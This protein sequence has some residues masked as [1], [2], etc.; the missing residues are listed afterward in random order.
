M[1]DSLK[2]VWFDSLDNLLMKDELVQYGLVATLMLD[3]G[4]LHG[5]D[6]FSEFT[7]ESHNLIHGFVVNLSVKVLA[8]HSN[9]YKC[10]ICSH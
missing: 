8:W 2:P 5:L 6:W 10:S 7:L 4:L 9:W 3:D 1:L